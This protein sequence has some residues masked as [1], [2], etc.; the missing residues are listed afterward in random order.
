MTLLHL[1]TI[2][3]TKKIAYAA[4][5]NN[6]IWTSFKPML[7]TPVTDRWKPC[8]KHHYLVLVILL[9]LPG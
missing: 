2:F 9:L 4:H 5:F 1:P 3:L 8:T 6:V 7:F